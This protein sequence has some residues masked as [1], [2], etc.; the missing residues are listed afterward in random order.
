M[1]SGT[2]IATQHYVGGAVTAVLAI[3]VFGLW[4]LALDRGDDDRHTLW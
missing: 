3:V 1:V 4:R 2:L